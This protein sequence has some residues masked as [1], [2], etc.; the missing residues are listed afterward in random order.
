MVPQ[1]QGRVDGHPNGAR[2][3]LADY[4]EDLR[5]IE[6]N[7]KTINKSTLILWGENDKYLPL[8]LGE[9]IHKDITGSKMERIPSCGHFIP[10]D[11]P[12]RA[13][14]LIAEFIGS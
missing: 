12:E 13:T 1:R 4:I 3:E 10:E 8:S 6:E 7:L 11:Q 5:F 2:R 9:R 14:E